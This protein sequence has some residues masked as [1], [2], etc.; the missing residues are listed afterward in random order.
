MTGKKSWVE[1]GRAEENMARRLRDKVKGKT[2][3][4]GK[5][6]FHDATG[7]TG[8][9]ARREEVGGRLSVL[10]GP[11][12]GKFREKVVLSSLGQWT[13]YGRNGGQE[14]RETRILLIDRDGIWEFVGAEIADG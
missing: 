6:K 7:W 8:R 1:M 14:G 2:G 13:V 4:R 11:R 9:V 10:V 12:E 3:V 5:W